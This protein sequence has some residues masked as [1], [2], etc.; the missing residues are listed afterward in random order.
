MHFSSISSLTCEVQVKDTAFLVFANYDDASKA[1]KFVA[2]DG[3]KLCYSS[4]FSCK[5]LHEHFGGMKED[6]LEKFL[7]D[8]FVA[9]HI[10]IKDSNREKLKLLIGAD[11]SNQHSID[12]DASKNPAGDI[13]ALL[14]SLAAKCRDCLLKLPEASTGSVRPLTF[15]ESRFGAKKPAA[16]AV[17]RNPNASLVLPAVKRRKEAKG[18]QFGEED[19]DE[20]D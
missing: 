13:K 6:I 7:R 12:L 16:S 5:R 19:S 4:E 8:S 2:T 10:T 18:V 11:H 14:F 17:R 1:I 3:N 20:S 9:A 15:E